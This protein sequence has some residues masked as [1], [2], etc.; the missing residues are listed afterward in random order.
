MKLRLLLL[1]LFFILSSCTTTKINNNEALV[2]VP[3]L[4]KSEIELAQSVGR[5]LYDLDNASA[6]G[7]DILLENDSNFS[8]KNLGGY[9]TFREGNEEGNPSDSYLVSFY[10]NDEPPKIKYEIHVRM[11]NDHEYIEYK[12]PKETTLSIRK[13]IKARQAAINAIP[14]ITQP[15]N[16]VILPGAVFGK[17]GYAI[18]LL[19]GTTEKDIAV[20]GRHYRA[21]VDPD[22]D[23]SFEIEPLSKSVLEIPLQDKINY[24]PV[25]VLV[26]QILTDWPTEIHV[27]A[28]LLYK[29]KI[30]VASESGAW[31]VDNGNIFFL[32]KME[33]L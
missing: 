32:G 33:D 7:T 25:A 14:E 1:A 27:F 4:Y 24:K 20:L 29:T 13:T 23:Y 2:G 3:S 8:E 12:P 16:P 31:A 9:I 30:Y 10:T 17:K 21:F 15:I 18:Y 5:M 19:A 22:N 26:N 11:N 28:S 6:I